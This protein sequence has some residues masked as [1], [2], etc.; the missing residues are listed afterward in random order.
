VKLHQNTPSGSVVDNNEHH[1]AA[2]GRFVIVAPSINVYTH[3]LTYL[4]NTRSSAIANK[5]C[6]TGTSVVVLRHN[7]TSSSCIRGSVHATV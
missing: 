2:L 4:L 7:N 6:H 3:L 5:T 1:L